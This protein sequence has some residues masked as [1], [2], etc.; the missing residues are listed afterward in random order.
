V[1]LRSLLPLVDQID[2]TSPRGAVVVTGATLSAGALG[3]AV[4]SF[5][6]AIGAF[7]IARRL[8]LPPFMER[9]VVGQIALA[10]GD[11]DGAGLA[12]DGAVARAGT[13]VERFLAHKWRALAANRAGSMADARTH[14]EGMLAAWKGAK[15]PRKKTGR[16]PVALLLGGVEIAAALP[17]GAP[18]HIQAVLTATPALAA[19][20]PHDRRRIESVTG[21]PAKARKTRRRKTSRGK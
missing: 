8:T 14:F 9:L 1:A 2:P 13:Q 10:A 19:D 16:Q 6:L 5:D 7:Q 18:A 15:A 20:F 3:M 4:G 12:L 21:L 11:V 17:P